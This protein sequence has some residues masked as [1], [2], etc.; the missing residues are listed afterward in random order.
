MLD[1]D[2]IK[3]SKSDL[4]SPCI[5]IQKPDGTFRLS[6]DFNSFTKADSYPIPRIDHCIDKI[7]N[8]KFIRKFALLKGY[9]QVPLTER[10]ERNLSMCDSQCAVSVQS[11]TFLA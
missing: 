9:L 10:A 2:I 5:F 6:T 4:N 3:I 7:E 11:D 1:N 8:A